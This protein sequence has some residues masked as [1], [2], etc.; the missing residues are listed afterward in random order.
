MASTPTPAGDG[1]L[2]FGRAFS[3]FF[4]DPEWVK[5]AIIGGLLYL[6]GFLTLI[7]LGAGLLLFAIAAGFMM[8]LL[9]RSWVGEARPLPA[10]EDYGG[11]LRDGIK[12]IGL[13]L[14]YMVGVY[15]VPGIMIAV[16][17]LAGGAMS[18]S[19][20]EAAGGLMALA[21]LVLQLLSAVLNLIL[22]L[23]L[24]SALTRMTLYQRFS[25]GFEVRENI[26][27]IRR[28]PKNYF[29][30]FLASFLANLVA[31]VGVLACC[32]GVFPAIFWSACVM[33]W[34][35]GQVARHDSFL[36]QQVTAPAPGV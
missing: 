14:A 35:F 7:L 25:A 21:I 28:N 31:G 9:Q 6:G 22:S 3:F 4:E 29:L 36:G 16:L 19:G 1:S 34:S 24:P 15:I 18:H 2:D 5:K 30:A 8:R 32:V 17:A 26:D 33:G 23:Y 27:F 20:S 13:S 12:A 10:W 11:L